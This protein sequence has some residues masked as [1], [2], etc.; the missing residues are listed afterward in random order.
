ML[1]QVA[2]QQQEGLVGTSVL[3]GPW[4]EPPEGGVAEQVPPD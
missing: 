1:A 2:Q 4:E 3:R